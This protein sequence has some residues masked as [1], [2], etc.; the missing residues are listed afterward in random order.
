MPNCRLYLINFSAKINSVCWTLSKYHVFGKMLFEFA[1]LC[2]GRLW[3][4]VLAVLIIVYFFHCQRTSLLG[5]PSVLRDIVPSLW[6]SPK[7]IIQIRR[8]AFPN[9]TVGLHIHT[10]IVIITKR[11]ADKSETKCSEVRTPYM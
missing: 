2:Y 6:V 5:L 10:K 1:A 4:S 8:T 11:D 3:Y 7:T 9:Q